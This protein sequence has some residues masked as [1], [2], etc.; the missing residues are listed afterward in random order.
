MLRADVL[1][2]LPPKLDANGNST[3]KLLVNDADLLSN[4]LPL[5]TVRCWKRHR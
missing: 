5:N 4:G 1:R 3:G 2:L